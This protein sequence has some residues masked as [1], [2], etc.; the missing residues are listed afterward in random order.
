MK[1]IIAGSR[2]LQADPHRIETYI[3]DVGFTEN[4]R[5]VVSGGARGIDTCGE[6]W[7]KYWGID[8]V[9]FPADWK[10][11]GKEAGVIRNEEMGDYADG[12]L[13]I[14]D[15]KSPGTKHMIDYMHKLGKRVWI[16]EIK[17]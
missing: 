3:D 5:K 12:L 1:L 9:R 16:K 13:A 8:V 10:T 2:T 7:A 14:W 17:A 4:V 11:Y 6:A 15:G